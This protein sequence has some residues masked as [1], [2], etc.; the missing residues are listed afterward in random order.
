MKK[1]LPVLVIAGILLV[2]L[3]VV[4]VGRKGGTGPGKKSGSAWQAIAEA[5]KKQK[6]AGIMKEAQSAYDAKDYSKAIAKTQGLLNNVDNMSQEAKN[7]L[8]ISQIRV[9]EL[10]G[11]AG[12][13][14]AQAPAPAN[15]SPGIVVNA[16]VTEQAQ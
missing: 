9:M 14:A 12:P 3:V 6:A 5:Q 2:V 1:F 13:A 11:Q 16:P 15:A 8:Q 7:L 4:V 10:S